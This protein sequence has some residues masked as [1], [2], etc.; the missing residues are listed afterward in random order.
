MSYANQHIRALRAYASFSFLLI[1]RVLPLMHP[2]NPSRPFSPFIHFH[3]A[4]ILHGV[5]FRNY[6]NLQ[7]RERNCSG[8]LLSRW[9]EFLLRFCNAFHPRDTTR[10][11]CQR[12]ATSSCRINSTSCTT[13]AVHILAVLYMYIYIYIYT[14]YIESNFATFFYFVY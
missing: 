3:T 9:Q 14:Q 10:V 4:L 2:S 7:S 12:D 13:V 11:Y 8:R 1:R 5:L 6:F